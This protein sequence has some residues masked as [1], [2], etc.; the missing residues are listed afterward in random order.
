MPLSDFL[1]PRVVTK[2]VSQ[3]LASGDTLSRHFGFEIGAAG[4]VKPG[5]PGL[6]YTYDI[7]NRTRRVATLRGPYDPAASVAARPVG[8]ITVG[9]LR[10]AE[11]TMLDYHK[12]TRIRTLG[13]DQLDDRGK[14]YLAK[15]ATELKRAQSNLREVLITGAILRGGQLGVVQ[16]GQDLLPTFETS[17]V[18]QTITW[19]VPAGN[20]LIGGSF[21]SGLQ[22]GTGSD[23]ITASWATASTDI[24][25][26]LMGI[27]RAF[28]AL[29]GAPLSRIYV[30]YAVLLNVL[31]NDKVRQLAGTSNASFASF[32]EDP[33]KGP[34]GNKTGL[35]QVVIKGLPQFTFYSYE[36]F[37]DVSDAN[38]TIASTAIMPASYSTFMVE[39]GRDW[40]NVVEGSE[41]YKENDWTEAKLADGFA[42]WI[43]EKSDPAAVELH[44]LQLPTIEN[45]APAGLAYARVM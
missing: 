38:G 32:T 39:P 23:I 12:L 25:A 11:K 8:N 24:P 17:G 18:Y 44:T 4:T 14:D 40:L 21:A 30:P 28:L 26:Q 6:T 7:F 22:M 1:T 35:V 37:L 33:I 31:Q 9:L 20:K 41:Y 42:A 16:T 13:G 43:K 29:V 5:V 45:T 10:S 2:V 27:S 34:D 3:V 36:G 15:Q 19:Q